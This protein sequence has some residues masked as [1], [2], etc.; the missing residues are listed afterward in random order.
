MKQQPQLPPPPPGFSLDQPMPPPPPGFSLDQP[1]PPPPPGFSLD[2]AA[3]PQSAA[4]LFA[5]GNEQLLEKARAKN[6]SDLPGQLYGLGYGAVKSVLGGAGEAE[7]LV[8]KT[9]PEYFGAKPLYEVNT[10]GNKSG[11][12]LPTMEQVK[13]AATSMGIPAPANTSAETVGEFIPAVKAGVSG[14]QAL[15][16]ALKNAKTARAANAVTSLDDIN[17]TTTDLYTA[18]KNEGVAITPSA[19]NEFSKNLGRDMTSQEAMLTTGSSPAIKALDTIQAETA[20]NAPI[21]LEKA[22]KIR[23]AVNGYV[24]EALRSGND[25][26]ARLAVVMKNKLDDFLNNLENN[27]GSYTGDASKAIPILRE[28]RASSQKGFKADTIR[29][30]KALAESQKGAKYNPVLVENKLRDKFVKLEQDLIENPSLAKG[31]TP[32]ER[33]AIQKVVQGGPVQE[34]MR[35]LSKPLP[36]IGS[37]GS[38]IPI[39][40]STAKRISASVGQKN[41]KL[42]D[43]LVRRGGPAVKTSA[44]LRPTARQAALAAALSLNRGQ[45]DQRPNYEDIP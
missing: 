9:V 17:K 3:P 39:I 45:D 10:L 15:A 29:E 14:V 7:N 36:I 23:A 38:V 4:D 37:Q 42:L 19:W 2:A 22:D 27:P 1:M 21:T 13:G 25:N 32:A 31:W 33:A 20:T 26:E 35:Q 41:V 34:V 6:R 8:R 43:E 5:P 16:G 18:A 30:F 28:A 24:K 44:N 40:G 12:F 11:T